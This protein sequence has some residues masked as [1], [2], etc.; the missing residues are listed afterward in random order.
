VRDE[1][2][3][4]AAVYSISSTP[5]CRSTSDSPA[6]TSS[7]PTLAVGG[8]ICGV[9]ISSSGSRFRMVSLPS[10][11]KTGYLAVAERHRVQPAFER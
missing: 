3:L 1:P 6:C 8:R 4:I 2:I 9:N 10:I 11:R 7:P 5:P